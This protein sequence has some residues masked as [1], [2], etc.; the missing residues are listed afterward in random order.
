MREAAPSGAEPNYPMR[1]QDDF[2]RGRLASAALTSLT[3]YNLPL[4]IHTQM[5]VNA[6]TLNFQLSILIRRLAHTAFTSLTINH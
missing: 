4:T 6:S 5:N 3:I 1:L 2:Q